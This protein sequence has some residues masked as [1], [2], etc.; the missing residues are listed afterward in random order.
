MLERMPRTS[1]GSHEIIKVSGVYQAPN[2]Q[3]IE[4]REVYADNLDEEMAHIRKIVEN[5][6]YIAM[7]S[8]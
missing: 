1:E 8:A 3:M 4:I 6:N 5:Y 7:V 2:G